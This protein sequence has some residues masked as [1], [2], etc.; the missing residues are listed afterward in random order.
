MLPSVKARPG[1]AAGRLLNGFC[2]VRYGA[3][4]A[5]TK[6]RIGGVI[7]QTYSPFPGSFKSRSHPVFCSKQDTNL[8]SVCKKKQQQPVAVSAKIDLCIA[9]KKMHFLLS[10][11]G[12]CFEF[13]SFFKRSSKEGA[14]LV[15]RKPPEKG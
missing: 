5:Q 4:S 15:K 1:I 14:N 2:R 11:F 10:F 13:G 3:G 12:T 7:R 9:L 8:Y 6:L